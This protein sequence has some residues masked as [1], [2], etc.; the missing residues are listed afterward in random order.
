MSLDWTQGPHLMM[1]AIHRDCTAGIS[2][3]SSRFTVPYARQFGLSCIPSAQEAAEE[4]A[5]LKLRF[6]H[7]ADTL[8]AAIGCKAC[9]VYER[10]GSNDLS[11]A[12][13]FQKIAVSTQLRGSSDTI[14]GIQAPSSDAPVEMIALD[15]GELAEACLI[16][17]IKSTSAG[18]QQASQ[19]YDS[20]LQVAFDVDRRHAWI[21]QLYY[22]A[23]TCPLK[24]IIEQQL[25]SIMPMIVDQSQL[26]IEARRHSAINALTHEIADQMSFGFFVVDEHCQL[27]RTNQTAKGILDERDPLVQKNGHLSIRR[28]QENVMLHACVAKAAEEHHLSLDSYA[29]LEALNGRNGHSYL[30]HVMPGGGLIGQ[31]CAIVLVFDPE[32]SLEAALLPVC[33]ALG[34]SPSESRLA[35][36]LSEGASLK[37]AAQKI[38]IKEY[39]ARTYLKQI[40]GKVRVQRQADLVRVLLKSVVPFRVNASVR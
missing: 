22:S 9:V 32:M 38:G 27:I 35:V 8:T 16:S 37:D 4:E 21:L 17:V 34:L 24:S 25:A 20:V 3:R 2:Q 33:R 12:T 14:P 10:T 7:F 15:N 23:P 6:H 30:I 11:V 36:A 13:L 39:T 31:S 26:L 28:R 40:F 18:S 29:V 5:R 1:G 19:R